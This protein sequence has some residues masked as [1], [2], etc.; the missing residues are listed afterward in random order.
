VWAGFVKSWLFGCLA[1]ATECGILAIFGHQLAKV[2]TRPRSTTVGG[3]ALGTGLT[4]VVASLAA[5]PVPYLWSKAPIWLNWILAFVGMSV[6]SP[7]MANLIFWPF[8]ACPYAVAAFQLAHVPLK[9][10]RG[11]GLDADTTSL[12]VSFGAAAFLLALAFL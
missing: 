9:L 6:D 1:L 3:F 5:L 11:Q 4:G 8:V 10:A 2:S 12:V 7:L